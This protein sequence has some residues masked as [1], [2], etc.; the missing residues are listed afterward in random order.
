MTPVEIAWVAGIIEG[1]GCITGFHKSPISGLLA[2]KMTDEDVVRRLAEITGVGNVTGPL[3]GGN[4]STKPIWAWRITNR[5][6]LARVLL[7]IAPLMGERR[8]ARIAEMAERLSL[9]RHRSLIAPCGTR[10]GANRHRRHGELLC[11]D[12]RE[13]ERFYQRSRTRRSA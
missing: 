12:C 8:R 13:A 2:V 11:E 9:A 7:A 6:D 10:S 3:S 1:E 5:K 4:R